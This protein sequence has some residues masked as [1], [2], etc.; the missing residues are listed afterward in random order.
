[1][2][3][4]SIKVDK[5]SLTELYRGLNIEFEVPC[6]E[7]LGCCEIMVFWGVIDSKYEN[8]DATGSTEV[9]R[10]QIYLGVLVWCL[11]F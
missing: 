2:W 9:S 6:A 1:M 7:T 10:K 5:L 11:P 4:N 8:C 3:K